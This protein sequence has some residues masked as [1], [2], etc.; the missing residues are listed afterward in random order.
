M[1]SVTR[2]LIADINTMGRTQGKHLLALETSGPAFGE[3]TPYQRRL[4]TAEAILRS[5]F[6]EARQ[7]D[8]G[9][10]LTLAERQFCAEQA[11]IAMRRRDP[12]CYEDDKGD[13]VGKT[14][15]YFRGRP[16]FDAS[17]DAIREVAQEA[18]AIFRATEAAR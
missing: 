15:A 17:E 6:E 14:I 2:Q 12:D 3:L 10:T 1:V 11:A 5:G 13:A 7:A 4:I 8:T 18:I 16:G 9:R